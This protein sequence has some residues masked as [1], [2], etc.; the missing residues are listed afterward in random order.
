MAALRCAG[1]RGT[2]NSKCKTF[3]SQQRRRSPGH[4]QI[5]R[6]APVRGRS[7]CDLCSCELVSCPRP[8][9]GARG[10]G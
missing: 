9:V 10:E 2:G 7:L 6:R 3:Q 5:C 8:R 1:A 4:A